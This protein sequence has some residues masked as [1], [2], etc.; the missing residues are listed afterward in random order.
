VVR[1][2]DIELVS[3]GPDGERTITL[4]HPVCHAAWLTVARSDD[5]SRQPSRLPLVAAPA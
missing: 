3:R 2:S 1:A 5:F 4:M